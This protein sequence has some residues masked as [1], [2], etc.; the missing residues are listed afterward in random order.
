M[1]RFLCGIDKLITFQVLN[2]T[3]W[4]YVVKYS[5]DTSYTYIITYTINCNGHL[6]IF[7]IK[8]NFITPDGDLVEV[9]KRKKTKT[10]ITNGFIYSG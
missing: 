2:S 10:K 7:L 8:Q 1:E 4:S 3:I 9:K 5:L 6:L